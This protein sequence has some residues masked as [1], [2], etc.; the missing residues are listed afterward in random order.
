[1]PCD[2]TEVEKLYNYLMKTPVVQIFRDY[3][4]Q[5]YEAKFDSLHELGETQCIWS[6]LGG[7]RSELTPKYRVHEAFDVL[8]KTRDVD[9]QS[10]YNW[11]RVND[12]IQLIHEGALELVITAVNTDQG[13]MIIDRNKRATAYHEY[14]RRQGEESIDFPLYLLKIQ[15]RT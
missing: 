1:M 10:T 11:N 5:L 9:E 4:I 6:N 15:P 13:Y 8:E 12:Y 7:V 14:H 2:T 3:N